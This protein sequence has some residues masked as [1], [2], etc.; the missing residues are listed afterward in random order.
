MNNDLTIPSIDDIKKT[1]PS[2]ECIID[3]EN[4]FVGNP[5]RDGNRILFHVLGTGSTLEEAW[6]ESYQYLTHTGIYSLE[7]K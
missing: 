2:L 6:S 4:Y 3:E 1:Y 5:E 7:N